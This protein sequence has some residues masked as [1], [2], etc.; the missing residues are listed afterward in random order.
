[1]IIPNGFDTGNFKPDRDARYRKR[2]ELG[3]PEDALVIGLIGRFDPMK[4]HAT[5]FAASLTMLTSRPRTHFILAGRGVSQENPH[6][7]DQLGHSANLEKVHLLGERD[8]IPHLLAACDIATSSSL[9]EGFPNVI[10]EAMACGVPCVS[11]DVGDAGLLMADTGF[12]VGKRAPRELCAAW[13]SIACMTPEERQ[14][15]GSRA[16]ERII[17][18]YSQD[19]T[20]HR[21]EELY[22]QTLSRQA[23]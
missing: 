22:R 4:D 14:V 13:E 19:R 8:D 5:F 11:T 3:I 16:R 12:L 6:I 20:T 18:Q 7:R 21:Y 17:E 1:V 9:S 23:P 2:S 15:L 10:G